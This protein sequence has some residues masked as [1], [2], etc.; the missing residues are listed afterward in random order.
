MP[1][2][3]GVTFLP[4]NDDKEFELLIRDLCALEWQDA[5]T[6]AFGR[7]GQTQFGVDVY[8]CPPQGGGRYRAAQYKLKSTGTQPTKREIEAEVI[9]ARSFPHGLEL[10]IIATSALRDT[11]TQITV[12]NISARE[13]KNNGFQV[14][15]WS[16]NEIAERIAAYPQVMVRYY[17]DFVTTLTGIADL[18]RLIDSPIRAC[19]LGASSHEAQAV[20]QLLTLRGVQCSEPGV[21]LQT[22][23]AN[24]NNVVA[25]DAVIA[26]QG[27]SEKPTVGTDGLLRLVGQ[28]LAQMGSFEPSTLIFVASSPGQ[29]AEFVQHFKDLGGDE[30]RLTF[31][32]TLTSPE[33][34]ANSLFRQL[35]RF[36]YRRRGSLTTIDISIRGEPSSP[37]S[38]LLDMDWHNSLSPTN[39]P[40]EQHWKAVL[41]PSMRTVAEEL[42][43][44]GKGT[45]LQVQCSL[46]LPAAVAFGFLL[47]LRV[48]QIGVWARTIGTSEF[49][50]QY[51][52][53]D[54]SNRTLP[55]SN[56]WIKQIDG[57]GST[58]VVE[59]GS[60]G[61][62][63]TVSAFVATHTMTPDAWLRVIIDDSI[64][65]MEEDIAL[66]AAN[67]L[68]HT[69]RQLN[70]QGICDTHLFLRIPSALAVLVGQRLQA[71]G[72]IHLY[73]YDNSITSY[74]R[75]FTLQ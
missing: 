19:V 20:V 7:S 32:S 28:L 53:S 5:S 29:F 18:E 73:W 56:D 9:A 40:S 55:C 52:H 59:F 54:A 3:S 36:A 22:L 70:A 24:P 51:W 46:P 41:W 39:L 31:I 25:P 17:H 64:R 67:H 27:P 1:P 37:S 71:C 21:Y 11:H 38:T 43:K 12:D 62:H 74:T 26:I 2:R 35:F 10:V 50:Q 48:A 15:I 44:L 4:P 14:I 69:I 65:N 75:A 72:R 23:R 58:A 61:I 16:W 47:N 68:A 13:F 66:G 33:Q 30:K 6:Q 60:V 57:S 8:G 42:A 45:R 34:V 49:K 63:P